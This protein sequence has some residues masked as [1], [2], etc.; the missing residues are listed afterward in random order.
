ME[1]DLIPNVKVRVQWRHLFVHTVLKKHFYGKIESGVIGESW[2]NITSELFNIIELGSHTFT[3]Y[4]YGSGKYW[5][6]DIVICRWAGEVE[7]SPIKSLKEL[8]P[9]IN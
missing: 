7:K 8:T 3:P 6:G 2:S 9:C 4:L 1:E 5:N